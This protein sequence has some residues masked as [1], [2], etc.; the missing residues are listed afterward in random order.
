M[1]VLPNKRQQFYEERDTIMRYQTGLILAVTLALC[2]TTF[3]GALFSDHFPR[4]VHAESV[5]F[6]AL[7]H[8]LFGCASG[9]NG[10]G[11]H[12]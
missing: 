2:L 3:S 1:N 12:Q 6:D 11:A 4:T 5:G 10:H 7:A 8:D 9:G